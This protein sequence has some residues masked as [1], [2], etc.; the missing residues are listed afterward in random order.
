MALAQTA[1]LFGLGIY[2][3]SLVAGDNLKNY[4]NQPSWLVLAASAIFLLL[5]A[6]SMGRWLPRMRN[7]EDGG[8]GT[9]DEGLA[10]QI[11]HSHEH[12][13]EHEHE[14]RRFGWV[15]PFVLSIPLVLG[16]LVPSQPLGAAAMGGNPNSVP[17]TVHRAGPAVVDPQA[18]NVKEWQV[19][20][21][22]NLHPQ[23]WFD[24]QKATSS[25]SW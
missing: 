10:V 12:K 16:I 11:P 8:R 18:W 19:A 7:G 20:M 17:S 22:H 21:Q 6:A 24:G 14:H 3:A 1:I 4:S 15:V 23:S 2:F 5:G 25:A 13:H 9:K